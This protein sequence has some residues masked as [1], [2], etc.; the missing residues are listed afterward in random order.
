MVTS[1]L[2]EKMNI[3]APLGAVGPRLVPLRDDGFPSFGLANLFKLTETDYANGVRDEITAGVFPFEGI[4]PDASN[5]NVPAPGGG[6]MV[7]KGWRA[8]TGPTLDVTK[9]WT[10][11]FGVSLAA[12]PAASQSQ[13]V[14]AVGNSFSTGFW[15]FLSIEAGQPFASGSPHGIYGSHYN[16]GTA[17]NEGDQLLRPWVAKVGAFHTLFM[18]HD[19]AGKFVLGRYKDG[20]F[21][22]GGPTIANPAVLANGGSPLLPVRMGGIHQN[23]RAGT[24]TYEAAAIYSRALD[25]TE[26]IKTS[27]ALFALAVARGRG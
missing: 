8:V 9:A 10:V 15:F 25:P 24:I 1:T 22:K 23:A 18:S 27:D 16:M 20:K 7:I 13:G 6:G 4:T 5:S 2:V 21:D 14:F 11:V 3:S 17:V 26:I 12:F 19:G